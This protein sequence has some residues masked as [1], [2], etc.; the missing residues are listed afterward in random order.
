[1][2]DYL[3]QLNESQRNAVRYNEGPELVIAGAGSGKTRVLTYKI[4]YM[5]SQG[6]PPGGIL[7]LTFTNKAAREMKARIAPIV[8]T[9]VARQI[10]MGT[11][12]SLFSR[13]LRREATW[14][15]YPADYTI[16]DAADSK[17]LL[18]T[19]VKEMQ[20]DDKKYRIGMVQA[21]ISKAKNALIT[22]EDYA[23]DKALLEADQ[24][25][26]LSR[27][28]EIYARYQSRCRKA[29]AMDFDDLLLLTDRLFGN[30]PEVLD[31]Y[32]SLFRYILV[33]E[34]Q[35][36]NYAQ[37]HIVQY[38][39]KERG[40]LC[41]VGDDA[42]SIYSFRGADIG[43]ILN[44]CK[45]YSN[46]RV[47]KLERNYRSTQ[48]IVNA[49]NSLIRKNTDQI[50]KTI[51]SENAVGSRLS[52]LSTYSDYEEGYA[53]AARI[54]AMCQ[55]G[56]A[57]A[58]C[59]ILYRTNAQSRIMEEALRKRSIPYRIYGGLSFYQRKEVKDLIAYFRLIVNPHDEEALKRVINYPARGIGETTVSKLVAAA[60]AQGVSLWTVLGAPAAYGLQVH[61][62][63]AHKLEEFRHLIDT[64]IRQAHALSAE[65]LATQVVK[66]SGVA[67]ALFQD[68][69]VE[70]MSKQENMQELLKGISE[71][72]EI[73]RE[74]G[75]E[76]VLLAD[77]LSEVALLT[78]QDNAKDEQA[79]MVTLMTIHAAKGLEFKH[80]FVVGME[81]DLFPTA[82][83]K[84]NLRAIEEERRLFYVALTRAEETCVLSYAR[85]RFRNG[86][87]VMC[88]PSRF[89][90]DIDACFLDH[91]IT[92]TFADENAGTERAYR[93]SA[94]AYVPPQPPAP[95]RIDPPRLRR[96]EPAAS[97]QP[98]DSGAMALPAG[99]VP[100]CKVYHD[101]FGEGVVLA[102]DG[103]GS[104]RKATIA[105]A[106]F[107][108][109]QLLLKFARL[110]VL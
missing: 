71:F 53:V 48:N 98:T 13:I 8:G 72:C 75:A 92:T 91:P 4:A 14:I 104:S 58:D 69:S 63:T 101:R 55:A 15:G 34:Y 43:N 102:F 47:F 28:H 36:T 97:S 18:R 56:F 81:E 39:C 73:R 19:I 1:M 109:K 100:G 105:F 38:L 88:S 107:G 40:N 42:Q 76:Q 74:E 79:D 65:E 20:L 29:G 64:F 61:S 6:M 44:F 37:H 106:T 80:V 86:Q 12:H 84:E 31:K 83:S 21:R 93:Q 87:T 89:L 67:K 16:Y 68:R 50:E 99:L 11:F 110:K 54:A 62:G 23:R 103:E 25:M 77:F 46:C 41:V 7:A 5:I 78:D 24:S 26:Q 35:D 85:H 66:E 10:W 70:G 22:A 59:A 3:N 108:K 33:D 30:H 90:K 17:N 57:Y 9:S 52:L 82:L 95:G 2:E 60:V 49:A 27:L 94:P 45:S 96:I 51:Y 32:R